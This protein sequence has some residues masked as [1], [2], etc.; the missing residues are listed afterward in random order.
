MY[1]I[2]SG[3]IDSEYYKLKIILTINENYD[4]IHIAYSKVHLIKLCKFGLSD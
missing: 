3:Y 4:H 1:S 2:L